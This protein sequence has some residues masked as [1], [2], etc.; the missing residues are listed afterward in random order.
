MWADRLA[1]ALRP[2]P[3]LEAADLGVRVVQACA[4]SLAR[5][6]APACALVVLIA[7]STWWWDPLAPT[8]VL[9]LLKPWLDRALLHVFARA[10]FGQPVAAREVW[11]RGVLLSPVALLQALTLR[12]LSPWRAYTQPVGQLEGLRGKPGRQRRALLLRGHRGVAVLHQLVFA[13]VE[14]LL[15]MAL[16]SLA[17]WLSPF[18]A[19]PSERG[20]LYRLFGEEMAYVFAGCQLVAAAAI[21]P[22]FVAS[23]FS[24]YLNR[25]VELEAWDVE[26]ELRRA[27]AA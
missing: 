10:A 2:R 21:E 18:D 24:M 4:P 12:R 25:R 6:Y 9:F 26:Q 11:H 20:G 27:F 23:G 19:E 1:L 7:A 22:F 3:M 16:M 15:A 8:L 5:A 17:Y 13:H 14:L